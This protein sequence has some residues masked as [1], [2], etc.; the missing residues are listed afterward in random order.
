MIGAG[1]DVNRGS[2]RRR[3]PWRGEQQP[4]DRG[5]GRALAA[6]VLRAAAAPAGASTAARKS[7]TS[8]CVYT[9]AVSFGSECPSIRCVTTSATPRRAMRLAA[10]CRSA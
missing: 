2:V 10:V 1:A 9:R 4:S 8:R 3:L 6:T 5:T 7:S